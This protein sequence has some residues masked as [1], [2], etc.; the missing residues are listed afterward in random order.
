MIYLFVV[1]FYELE[2]VP[3]R[4]NQWQQWLQWLRQGEIGT[5]QDRGSV[6]QSVRPVQG[7]VPAGPGCSG[8]YA[9]R[10]QPG[11]LRRVSHELFPLYTY[12]IPILTKSSKIFKQME[13]PK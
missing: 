1:Q 5:V 9:E 2:I 12:F 10:T 11:H 8:H 4:E 13:F 7:V 3:E 6:R